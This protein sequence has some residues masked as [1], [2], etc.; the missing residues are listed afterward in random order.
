M[1]KAELSNELK[2]AIEAVKKGAETALS[3]FDNGSD[4]GETMKEDNT[5]VTVADPATEETIKKHILS[6][7]P[8]ANILGEE[9]GGAAHEKSFWIIDPIDGTRIYARGINTWAVLLSYCEG[10]NFKIGVC[11][12]P[13]LNELYYAE[14]GYGAF[15]NKNK[16]TVSEIEP[17]E[18][19]L[20]NSGNPR[21]FK[22]SEVILEMINEARTVRGYETT[23]ADCL[24]ASGKMEGS[25]DPYA[26][27]WDYAAFATIISEA[28]GKIT[29][30]KG[31]NLSF[32][33][34]GCIMSNGLIHDELIRIVN[35]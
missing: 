5:N 19:A 21:Y 20:V 35:K 31:K 24:V 3:F 29:N 13:M 2:T 4:L 17:L 28:G 12:F 25:I 9:T 22:N 10:N 27:L 26:A 7:F 16:I 30:L 32:D 15:M 23:Y 14:S 18:K 34:R 11:Y 6:K 1:K 8:D 33:D